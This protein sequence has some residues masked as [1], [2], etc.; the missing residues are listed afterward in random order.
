MCLRYGFTA[1]AT[2]D[3]LRSAMESIVTDETDPAPTVTPSQVITILRH[4]GWDADI[5]LAVARQGTIRITV[6]AAAID[7]GLGADPAPA[8]ADTVTAMLLHGAVAALRGAGLR[9]GEQ[10][11]AFVT[12]RTDNW[13][14]T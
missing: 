9:N 13:T 2:D 3:L 1:E 11:T 5:F 7:R 4:A 6:T 8:S 14:V 10:F 12:V